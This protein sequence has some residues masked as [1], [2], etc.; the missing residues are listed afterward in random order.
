M[1]QMKNFR[2]IIVI[3][4][5]ICLG[6]PSLA[7]A[8]EASSSSKEA[9]SSA[10][11]AA[12]LDEL[13]K[14][15][16]SKAASLKTQVDKKLSNKAFAGVIMQLDDNKEATTGGT[17]TLATQNG[18][19]KAILNE[20]TQFEDKTAKKA[21]KYEGLAKDDFVVTLGDVDDRG[22]MMAK[23]VVKLDKAKYPQRQIVWGK[24]DQIKNPNLLVRTIDKTIEL[25]TGG[26]TDFWL[27]NEE[28]SMVDAKANKHLIA[29]SD[30]PADNNLKVRFVYLIPEVGFYVP[31][32][33]SSA[34]P[35]ATVKPSPTPKN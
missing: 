28:A 3:L 33:N 30:V 15:I 21:L 10:S 34:T 25:I 12:K 22:E 13:K 5:V 9:S 2:F 17:L 26:N 8:Q 23:K 32:K 1:F 11:I 35:S 20:Y 27:G 16:A 31:I 4:I 6:F 14:E 7:R 19:Q 29:V 24:I 18:T